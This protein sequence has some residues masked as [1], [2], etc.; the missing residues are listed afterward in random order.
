MFKYLFG[1]SIA[2]NL[3]LLLILHHKSVVGIVDFIL[4][5]MLFLLFSS[6]MI[7][8]LFRS[9]DFA[10]KMKYLLRWTSFWIVIISILTVWI[11]YLCQNS[12]WETAIGF[13]YLAY[14]VS[15]WW[16]LLAFIAGIIWFFMD[17]YYSKKSK[18]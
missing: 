14:L 11:V 7:F 16:A 17:K 18:A 9:E 6:Y 8:K 10:N 1:L 2:I 13:W 12:E 3:I 4:P 5:I 15:Y